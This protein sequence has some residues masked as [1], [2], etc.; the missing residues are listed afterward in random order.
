MSLLGLMKDMVFGLAKLKLGKTLSGKQRTFATLLGKIPDRIPL[1]GVLTNY[2]PFWV[3]PSKYDYVNLTNEPA[4]TLEFLRDTMELIPDIDWW[5]EPWVGGVMLSNGAYECG[6]V[7]EF[8]RETFAYPIKYPVNEAKDLDTLYLREGGYLGKYIESLVLICDEFPDLFCPPLIP[9][10]WTLGTFVRG[11]DRIIQDFITYKSYL[12]TESAARRRKLERS[13]EARAIHP[14]FWEREM[15][16]YRD[17]CMEI[18]DRH[19]DAGILSF[20]TVGYDLYASPPNLDVDSYIQ[21]VYPYAKEVLRGILNAQLGWQAM[22]PE[23]IRIMKQVSKGQI[24]GNFGYEIDELGFF[25]RWFDEATIDVAAE[26]NS[27]VM[28]QICPDFLR[29]A[30]ED[31][32]RGYVSHLCSLVKT[33][34]VP[35][36]LSIAGIPNHTPKENVCAVIDVVLNEGYYS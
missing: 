17:L 27:S 32:I 28:M 12:E 3:N 4:L 19:K 23:E 33:K 7:F 31:R 9:C 10:P 16:V 18:R 5:G 22:N 30:N 6:T 15:E 11:A 26:F 21:Y 29:D 34:R 24:V 36:L 2:H 25:N 1:L 14:L 8:P 35:A 13:A 20:G